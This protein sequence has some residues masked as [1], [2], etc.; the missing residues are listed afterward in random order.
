MDFPPYQTA[1]DWSP[2]LAESGGRIDV[3]AILV[4]PDER[5]LVQLRDDKPGIFFP[6][7]WGGFGG[8]V[9]AGET[10]E[11]AVIRE[12]QEELMFTP[13][14]PVRFA[15]LALPIESLEIPL[16][17]KVFYEIKITEED[18][19]RM[20]QKEGADKKLFKIDDL[21]RQPKIVP[22]DCWGM[23]LHAR[24]HSVLKREM[25]P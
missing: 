15:E 1:L 22:W 11:Q 2:I 18:I 13:H 8:A 6:G 17:V 14:D 16:L 12:L 24:R 10:T 5:Y 9:E 25:A 4:T 20:D 21:M 19:Q 7:F 23:M 3:V